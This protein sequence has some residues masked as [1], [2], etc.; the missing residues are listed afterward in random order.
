MTCRQSCVQD[1]C[2]AGTTFQISLCIKP[3]LIFQIWIMAAHSRQHS[4]SVHVKNLLLSPDFSNQKRVLLC[5]AVPMHVWSVFF[6]K[7]E[8]KE[9][10]IRWQNTQ[11]DVRPCGC[12]W[13]RR[14]HRGVNDVTVRTWLQLLNRRLTLEPAGVLLG[15][16]SQE[17]LCVYMR[18]A[19]RACATVSPCTRVPCGTERLGFALPR[20]KNT[21]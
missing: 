19:V 8:R 10:K 16:G 13:P 5:T 11:G 20:D 9:M 4:K 6:L 18:V 17:P 1:K 21:G 2:T 7:Q 12:L 3:D 14:C 15:N